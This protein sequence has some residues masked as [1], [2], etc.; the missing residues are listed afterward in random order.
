MSSSGFLQSKSDTKT[1]STLNTHDLC[2]R[3]YALIVRHTYSLLNTCIVPRTHDLRSRVRIERSFAPAVINARSVT[4]TAIFIR[5]S[6]CIF[7]LCR[8]QPIEILIRPRFSFVSF[9]VFFCLSSANSSVHAR[10]TAFDA[11][12]NCVTHKYLTLSFARE[13]ERSLLLFPC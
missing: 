2:V 6:I 4:R 9:S 3:N 7:V 8:F 11:A 12:R 13:E 10:G 5:F 1:K